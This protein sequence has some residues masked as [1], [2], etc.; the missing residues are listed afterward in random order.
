MAIL[1]GI[2]SIE[3]ALAT[4]RPLE[5]LLVARDFSHGRAQKLVEA[6]RAA[7]VPVRFVTRE[8]L[9]RQTGTRSHQ[10][11]AAFVGAKHYSDLE[12]LIAAARS[13]A[14]FV[15]LDGIED[16]HNLGAILRTAYCAGADGAV[17][18]ERRAAGIT[19]VVEKASA[20]A[21]EHLPVARVT[22]LNRALE[23]LKKAG[24]W[25]VGLD[26]GAQKDFTEVDLTGSIGL[27]LGGEGKGLHQHVRAKCDFL[28][29]IPT[30]GAIHSLNVSVA[31][32][33]VLYEA[34][35][36]RRAKGIKR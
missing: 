13:P 27:V 4:R 36:Q 5:R 18:P 29:S 25:L 24:V 32:G 9:D 8:E 26:E 19:A 31:A 35:R 34:V 14:L 15:L 2:H 7:G 17:L 11:V 20:G 6:A 12:D 3:Q 33:V 16:P 22:N 28:V 30:A 23:Q 21:S 1:Y 10:G